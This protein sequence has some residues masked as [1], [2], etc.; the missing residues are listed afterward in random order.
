VA[1]EIQISNH[2]VDV[3]ELSTRLLLENMGWSGAFVR[4]ST[5]NVRPER[6]ARL[7]DLVSSVGAAE[8]LCGTGGARYLDEAP[9]A[10]QGIVVRY[11]RMPDAPA[12]H[13]HKQTSGLWWLAAVKWTDLQRLFWERVGATTP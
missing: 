13:E 3:T 11:V 8:Y 2:L 6:S 7:A 12:L 4:S 1:T 9:F 5:F 10:E